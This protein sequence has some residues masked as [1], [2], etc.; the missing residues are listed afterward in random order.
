MYRTSTHATMNP[1]TALISAAKNDAPNVSRNDA[2]TTGEK[3]VCV[4]CSHVMPPT[5]RSSPENGISTKR[6]R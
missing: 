5:F 3:I 6:L 4:Y 1:N 2:K